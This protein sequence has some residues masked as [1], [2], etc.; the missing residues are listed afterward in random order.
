MYVL[1]S[2]SDWSSLA[3][4]SFFVGFWAIRAPDNLEASSYASSYKTDPT[5]L[6]KSELLSSGGTRNGPKLR[7]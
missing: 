3:S 4:R 1:S 7:L 6:V 5:S 2:I